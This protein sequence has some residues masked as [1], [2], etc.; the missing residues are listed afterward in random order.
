MYYAIVRSTVTP[1]RPDALTLLDSLPDE[2]RSAVLKRCH[3]TRH[4][5]GDFIFHV[6]Q[7]G[8]A[9]HV[10]TKGRVT[11]S[12]G[13]GLGEP[14]TLAVMGVGEAFGEMALIDPD[15]AR[16][17]TIRAIEPTETLVLLQADFHE[18]RRRSPAVN[19]LLIR[20]LVAR[21][22]RLTNQL[23]ELA[24]LPA[25]VRIHRQVVALGAL[26][27]VTD[28][29]RPIP[30]SQHQVAS[31][32]GAKLRVTNKVLS[33]AR[34]AGTLSTGRRRI[35]VHDWQAVRRAARQPAAGAW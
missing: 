33:E 9:L 3:R 10:I 5:T 7:K 2:E 13:G 4:A 35:V 19:D 32:A 16:T 22:R 12:A 29:D 6:G 23:T 15:E 28:T 17:A 18:L 11:A 21:V 1:V 8:D 26:F 31:L 14:V 24:E 27:E 20:V 34:T 25:P 30:V